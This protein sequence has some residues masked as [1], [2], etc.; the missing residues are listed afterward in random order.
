MEISPQ[1]TSARPA[2]DDRQFSVASV[3]AVQTSLR[4]SSFDAKGRRSMRLLRMWFG[5]AAVLAATMT[6]ASGCGGPAPAVVVASTPTGGQVVTGRESRPTVCEPTAGEQTRKI[7]TAKLI[8]EYNST[9]GDLGVHGAFDDHGWSELCVLDPS[10]RPILAVDP[11]GALMR[12][13]MAGI[14]FESREP[15]VSEFS[16]ADLKAA[17]PAGMYQVR[18]R[19]FDGPILVGQAKFTHDV[20]APPRITSPRIAEEPEQLGTPIGRHDVDI[21]WTKVTRSTDGR[22]IKIA[23]YEVIV[24]KVV[25]DDTHGFSRPTYDVHVPARITELNV[26]MEFLE[27]GAVY[28]LEVLAL[29]QSGNQTI[30]VGLF[31]TR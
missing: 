5:M 8:I 1:W 11:E 9:D 31:T 18:G 2:A 29:E 7:A 21:E 4:S 6:L 28:E 3:A 13:T 25:D 27:S 12:L 19:S 30:S 16:M 24:T 23:G 22:P 26:P 15:P 14:F 20:P 10:G 17:F